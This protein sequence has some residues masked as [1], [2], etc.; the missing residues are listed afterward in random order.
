MCPVRFYPAVWFRPSL[1]SP[2]R[3]PS[4][5]AGLG[6]RHPHRLILHGDSTATPHSQRPLDNIACAK[7]ASLALAVEASVLFMV[8]ILIAS[9]R[10]AFPCNLRESW[11]ILLDSASRAD[12]RVGLQVQWF[13]WG[14]G[15]SAR[16][17]A[18]PLIDISMVIL[19]CHGD[20]RNLLDEMPARNLALGHW[21][22]IWP[23][24]L[25]GPGVVVPCDCMGKIGMMDRE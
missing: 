10:N 3:L 19:A 9:S 4:P 23:A 11:S 5:P 17:G 8:R 25:V 24:C 12:V 13:S 22:I 16:T 15:C 6:G 20:A 1:P 7:N 21:W 14:R 18:A 2:L